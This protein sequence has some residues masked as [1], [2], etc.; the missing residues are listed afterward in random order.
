[1]KA[2]MYADWCAVKSIFLRYLAIVLVIVTPIVAMSNADGESAPGVFVAAMSVAML[3]FY[4]V[5]SLFGSD[6][7]QG[8]EAFRLSFPV[9]ARMVVRGRYAF[10]ACMVAGIC[11]LGALMGIAVEKLLP[12][13]Q[14]ALNVPRGA[15]VIFLSALGAALASLAV[16]SLEMPLLFRLGMSRARM[17]FTLPFLL[18]L[19]PTI[20]P[21]RN[22]LTGPV[23]AIES[24]VGSLPSPLPLF[25]GAALA[26]CALYLASMTLSERLYAARDF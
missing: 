3:S 2:L 21:V 5:I 13:V 24:F 23:H 18:F 1:M 14:G 22:A 6:E 7:W 12:V 26:V 4:L 9:D 11:L 20:E 19:L 15:Q 8:W 16:L 25:A 17:A 10:L